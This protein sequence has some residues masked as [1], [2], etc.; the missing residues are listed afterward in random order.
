MQP[1][2]SSGKMRAAIYRSYGAPQVV[3]IEEVTKP[4]PKRDEV[5]IKIHATTVSSG[6][7]RARSLSM[8]PGFGPLAP[9]VFG[10]FG[11]RQPILGTELSG[12]IEA[13]G[14]NVTKFK[15]G[16]EVFAFPSFAMG[17]HAEY[18][19]LPQ[20]GLI[21]LKPRNLSFAEAAALSFGGVTAL[22]F[23]RDGAKI[24]PG[25]KV[26]VIGASGAVG[27]AAVQLANYF[28]AD[29]TGVCSAA[30]GDLV[31]S[32]GAGRTID[33]A[34][35]SALNDQYDIICDT[36][37]VTS[38]AACERALKPGG[39]LLLVAS[40]LT[41]V[42]GAGAKADGKSVIAG[43]GKETIEHIEFLKRLAEAGA[44]KPVI[45]QCLPLDEINKA[46]Q[47]VDSGRKKGSVVV[48]ISSEA[49]CMDQ[50]DSAVTSPRSY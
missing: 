16:D 36:I 46:H 43:P 3:R 21:A 27:S 35:N 30:N 11:P 34:A 14:A 9:L 23:L 42:L 19:A 39:R 7:W 1:V 17:A 8:P 18:R 15:V 20:D 33:Y 41:Q 22:R 10:V 24:L 25:E 37:G 50:R 26:L 38:F 12:Q 49:E 29:V 48:L 5:L 44:F 32:I 31:K 47:R 4:R 13:V 40:G 45:D 2:S 28:G 6:D